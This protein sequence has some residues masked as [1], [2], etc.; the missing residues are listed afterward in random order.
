MEVQSRENPRGGLNPGHLAGGEIAQSLK[1]LRLEPV[2]LDA[3]RLDP[4]LHPT[5]IGG[6]ESF[7]ARQGL[8]PDVVRGNASELGA[9]D[10]EVVAEHAVESNLE[11]RDPRP[12]PLARLESQYLRARVGRV[13]APLVE[14]RVVPLADDSSLGRD[15]REL[16]RQ[17]PLKLRSGHGKV[18]KRRPPRLGDG[19]PVRLE[20]FGHAGEPKQR[21]PNRPQ[22][23]RGGSARA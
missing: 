23:A 22:V 16:I 4:L 5:E 20:R 14:N 7:R 12:G 11:V 13:S 17:A 6:D 2:A 10:F 3:R 8:A 21:I 18:G 1:V 9:R 15:E 19:I